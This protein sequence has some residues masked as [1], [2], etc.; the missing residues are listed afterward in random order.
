MEKEINYQM[1][2]SD[3]PVSNNGSVKQVMSRELNLSRKEI[4]RLKYDGEILLNGQRIRVNDHM[5]VG[6]TLTLRFPEV[7][8]GQIPQIETEPDILYEDEDIVIV[9]KPA[10]IPC[11][12]VHGHLDD[13]AGSILAAYYSR[14]GEDFVIRPIGRLDKDVSGVLMFAKNRLAASRL[15]KQREE[16][17]MN[18][19]YIAFVSGIFDIKQGMI[20]A[21]IAKVE[22]ERRRV[23][24]GP[25]GKPAV[26]LFRVVNEFHIDDTSISELAVEIETGRTHQIRAHM[27]ATGHPLIGDELY[28]GDTSFLERPALHC[29][30]VV[31]L[32]PFTLEERVVKAP[33][34]E[35]MRTLLDLHLE[36]TGAMKLGVSMDY[37]DGEPDEAYD[38]YEDADERAEETETVSEPQAAEPEPKKTVSSNAG[39]QILEQLNERYPSTRAEEPAVKDAGTG[40]KLQ[41]V[42]R[43]LLTILLLASLGMLVWWGYK[44]FVRRQTTAREMEEM[45]DTLKIV[46]REESFVEYGGDFHPSDY[47]V[48]AGGSL[49]VDGT[50]DTM[51]L[52]N[53]EVTYTVSQETS[54]GTI[55]TRN[56]DKVFTVRDGQPPVITLDQPAVSVSSQDQYDPKNNVVSVIDP[57]DGDVEYEVITGEYDPAKSG[58]YLVE[59]NA[60]DAAGN[61][62]SK[63]FEVIVDGAASLS[64]SPAATPAPT[65]SPI[66]SAIPAPSASPTPTAPADQT[67]PVIQLS[68][69]TV[70][71]AVNEVFD[72][73]KYIRSAEDETDGL[74][75]Y[76]ESLIPGS[77]TVS[78]AVD[79]STP[80]EYTVT[81]TALDKAGNQASKQMT[82]TVVK[83]EE[84]PAPTETPAPSAEP[85]PQ[86]T[87]EASPASTPVPSETPAASPE[88][89]PSA[90][91]ANIVPNSSDPKGQ[92]YSFLTGTMGFNKAQACGILAN[93][94][95][96]SRFNST[97]DN[98]IGYYGLCQWGG[99]RKDNLFSWCKENGYDPT[100]IDG[101]LHFLQYEM[102]LFYPNTTAQFKAC[103]NDEEG[104][105]KASWI[106][107]IGYEVAGDYYAEMS[108]DKAAEYFNE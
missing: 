23:T 53:H 83:N 103:P 59:V 39:D 78:S 47:V 91:A 93:M 92:I 44:Q 65:S 90:P 19:N 56:Y 2:L 76:S 38:D 107:A 30:E 6:D 86:E 68:T 55:V 61:V 74:L 20:D 64:E 67:A 17:R 42:L 27:A 94:H 5:R 34:P 79:S 66:P 14:K 100:T 72:A 9:N 97:A 101:Q 87:T 95:R 16:G 11:H 12:P 81:I 82:V 7:Q 58:S 89:T 10:G 104:A 21:P 75:G 43:V 48:S 62:S 46:F 77:F 51:Q 52:G 35:D 3:W 36:A 22:G 33:L 1:N 37:D 99:E 24:K 108:M 73:G 13:S 57:V 4:S 84:T 106:F 96:E 15:S 18:K 45:Y 54:D 49:S 105:R 69:D 41:G 26:T 102:P 71:L 25:E 32:T 88:A 28:G 63:T 60:S 8:T 31:F 80:G 70:S 85:T 29:S 40:E 50:V 98:G